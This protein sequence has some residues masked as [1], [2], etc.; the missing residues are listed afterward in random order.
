[1]VCAAAVPASRAPAIR[2]KRDRYLRMKYS[3][4]IIL[5]SYLPSPQWQPRPEEQQFPGS[6]SLP[7]GPMHVCVMPHQNRPSL[8][9]GTVG[10]GSDQM[11]WLFQCRA[12]Q[13]PSRSVLNLSGTLLMLHLLR[14]ALRPRPE[15]PALQPRGPD[16][17]YGRCGPGFWLWLL[18]LARPGLP[19]LA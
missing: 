7:S 4:A 11:Y 14:P 12:E 19:W 15:W 8:Q 1:M 17:S 2:T 3:Y 10:S 9:G 5:G 18:Q 13:S 6:A 16:G